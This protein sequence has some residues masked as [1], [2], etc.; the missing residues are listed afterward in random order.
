MMPLPVRLLSPSMSNANAVPAEFIVRAATAADAAEIARI[1]NYYV[2]NTVITFEESAVPSGE[3]AERMAE[4]G[5][6]GLPWL[7]AELDGKVA[8]YS[9]ATRWK[10]RAAYRHSVETTVYLQHG[11][12]G[13]GIGRALYSAL[14]PILREC[15]IHAVIGGAA[16]PNAASVALHESLGFEQVATF[17]Q[18]GFK[19]GRWVDVAYWQRV[20]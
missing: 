5:S 14:L 10:T 18:V 3:M 2:E 6:H 16:L 15:G 4:V 19:H 12:T 1:Y 9:Y 17:R 20:L 7:V 13:R 8:G 11:L